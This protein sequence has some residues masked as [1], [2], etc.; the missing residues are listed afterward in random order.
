M[1][2]KQY[3]RLKRENKTFFIQCF[4]MDRIELIKYRLQEFIDV[5]PNE[6]RLYI[7]DRVITSTILLL[8]LQADR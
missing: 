6:M 2:D 5:D 4:P 7:G 1:S 3:V 8:I